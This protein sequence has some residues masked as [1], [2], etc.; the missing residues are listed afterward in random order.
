MYDSNG[1]RSKSFDDSIPHQLDGQNNDET[2]SYQFGYEVNAIETGD[3]KQHIE[4]RRKN[5]VKGAF[6]LIEPNGVSRFVQYIANS[7]GFNAVARHQF[8]TRYSKDFDTENATQ[9][10]PSPQTL[11]NTNALKQS[12]KNNIDEQLPQRQHVAFIRFQRKP[13]DKYSQQNGNRQSSSKSIVTNQNR[14]M[15]SIAK[16]PNRSNSTGI[17]AIK[18]EIDW[19]RQQYEVN[20]PEVDIDVRRSVPMLFLNLEKLKK[21]RNQENNITNKSD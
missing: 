13:D 4:T 10:D 15:N 14:F 2:S 3:V 17:P 16:S 8:G 7:N 18:Q 1:T 19:R 5:E 12:K 20:D 21:T 9:S 11:H 6:F